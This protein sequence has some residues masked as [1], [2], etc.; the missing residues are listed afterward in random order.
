MDI[1]SGGYSLSSAPQASG[2]Y[3]GVLSTPGEAD[4]DL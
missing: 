2:G 1:P 3:G 4:A